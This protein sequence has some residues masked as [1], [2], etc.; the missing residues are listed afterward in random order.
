[1][2]RPHQVTQLI[3]EG[4]SPRDI[5]ALLGITTM[6]VNKH[7]YT[8]MQDGLLKRSELLFA[9]PATERAEFEKYIQQIHFFHQGEIMNAAA[10]D[11]HPLDPHH[12]RPYLKVRSVRLSS[13]DMYELLLS[14]EVSLHQEIKAL[15]QAEYGPVEWWR[16]GVPS[17]VR[18]ECAKR[19]EEDDEPASEPY[20]YTNFIHLSEIMAKQW[21]LF[22]ACLPQDVALEKKALLEK[23]RRLNRIRNQV[24]HPVRG[25]SPTA[26]DFEFVHEFAVQMKPARWQ[27]SQAAAVPAPS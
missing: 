3:R 5:A 19:H 13:G 10:T 8:A 9:I 15:L 1:V 14:V 4:L 6:A 23:L 18:V 22:S 16:K 7:L 17:D 21:A 25:T 20:C 26:E 24:M 12:L 2:D 11:G 27:R